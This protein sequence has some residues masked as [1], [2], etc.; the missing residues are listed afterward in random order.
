MTG[1]E[2]SGAMVERAERRRAG[3]PEKLAENLRYLQADAC[4]FRCE[5][6]FDAVVALFH[7]INY[8]VET[9]DLLRLMWTAANHLEEGG[10]FLF[11]FWFGPAVLTERPEQRTRTVED[12]DVR[13]E[14]R[15]EPRLDPARNL[16]EV[17]YR[18]EVQPKDGGKAFSF[19]EVHL[20]R[21]L[22]LPEIEHLLGESGFELE[23]CEQWLTGRP[24]GFDTWYGCAVARRRVRP[25]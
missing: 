24:L 2:L 6:R 13:V 19:Q 20:M 22:F 8:Q 18:F 10:L 23:N 15:V 11:D 21:Y 3:L 25:A 4:S 5:Q 17:D 9:A 1:V 7:V 12:D 14:R 16:V